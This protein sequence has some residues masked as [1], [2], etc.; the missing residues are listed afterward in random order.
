MNKSGAGQRSSPWKMNAEKSPFPSLE[1]PLSVGVVVVGGGIAGLT[2]ALRLLEGGKSVALVE[3]GAVGDGTT[4]FS[5]GHLTTILD[6]RWATLVRTFGLSDASEVFNAC[7]QA[8]SAIEGVIESE[9]IECGYRRLPGY[10][11][12]ESEKDVEELLAEVETV[13]RFSDREV[14]FTVEI[15]LPFKTRAALRIDG[16][17]QLDPFLYV[18]GLA[19]AFV[20]RGGLLFEQTRVENIEPTPGRVQTNRGTITTESIVLA[21]HTPLGAKHLS[22][23]S[24]LTAC[25]SY[26]LCVT[27]EEPLPADGLFWDM[28]DPYHYINSFEKDGETFFLIGGADHKTGGEEFPDQSYQTLETYARSNFKVKDILYRWS[29]QYFKPADGLPF[30]GQAP[31]SPNV[32]VATGFDGNGLV[33]GTV[34]GIS[35]AETLLGLPNAWER[36]FNPARMKPAESILEVAR[37]A[38]MNATHFIGDRL[39]A[40]PVVDFTTLR[41]GEGE[42]VMIDGDRIAAYRDDA[43][44]LHT[45]SAVCTHAGCIVKWNSAESTWDCPCHGGRYTAH[46]DILEGPPLAPLPVKSVVV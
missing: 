4:G 41:N 11:F 3:A 28:E 38:V 2:T 25:F 18:R 9:N 22:I 35:L 17:A 1:S 6:T 46:G 20:K 5:T 34:A 31:S 8:I 30:I 45:L 44:T 36:L 32:Y 7:N 43:G 13:K 19:K 42:V 21:T 29:A 40:E 15:P 24:Q 27:L 37:E 16:Q 39:A 14:E 33:L 23:Q 10:L 26:V 12:T